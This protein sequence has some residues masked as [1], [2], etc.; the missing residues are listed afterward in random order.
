MLVDGD[1]W[2]AERRLI[3]RELLDQGDAATAAYEVA[4]HHGAET[5]AQQ[6]EAEFHAGWIALRFLDDAARPRASTLRPASNDRLDADLDRPR[7]LLAGPR[8]RSGRADADAPAVLRARRRQAD[9]LL[10]PARHARSLNQ[11]V[12]LRRSNRSRTMPA[13]GAS[14][15]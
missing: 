12:E 1:E 9:H 2:W 7:R 14:R 11:P 3:T 8:G 13:G 6:I 15:R 5:P 4:S 10:W